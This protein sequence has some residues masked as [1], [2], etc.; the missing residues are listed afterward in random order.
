MA[1]QEKS[2]VADTVTVDGK[3]QVEPGASNCGTDEIDVAVSKLGDECCVPDLGSL[4]ALNVS[5]VVVEALASPVLCGTGV[6]HVLT[7][8]LV[9]ELCVPDLGPLPTLH[10]SP[11]AEEEPISPAALPLWSML[12]TLFVG[13]AAASVDGS[14]LMETWAEEALSMLSTALLDSCAAPSILVDSPP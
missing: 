7:A 3:G 4:P 14:A 8:G 2:A 10:A 9:E 13:A 6:P 11:V 5:L 1:A 12:G